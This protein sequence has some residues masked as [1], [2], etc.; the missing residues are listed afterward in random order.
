MND[1]F[2]K[3][4][5]NIEQL[6]DGFTLYNGVQ[7]PVLGFGTWLMPNDDLGIASVRKALEAGYRHI[8]TAAV[9]KNEESVRE[10]I[11]QS[12][13]PREEIFLTTKLAN[14]EHGYETSLK[15]FQASLERLGTDY[16]D[17][18]LIHWP[19][20]A[21]FR[22]CWEEANAETWRAFEE[23]YEA[24][25]IRAIGVSNFREHHLEALAK[26]WK[27]KPMVN[28]IHLCPGNLPA[29]QVAY[30]LDREILIESYSPL[31]RGQILEIETLRELAETKA[32]TIPQI[33]LRWHLQKGFVAL[34]KSVTPVY[35]KE[36][37]QIFDFVLSV[38]EM[39]V[40]DS[41][42]E[43]SCGSPT[44]PDTTDF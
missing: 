10:G 4:A 43:G 39:A 33:V 14:P 22:N 6:S 31:G 26:S 40:I 3:E 12:G 35:I 23:L 25:K 32:K 28:Q 36:N 42:L 29:S 16:V 21:K 34:P 1:Q 30:C 11:R 15:A 5:R 2:V 17:L 37:A 41:V 19:N 7:I 24:G 18:Y 44:D 38:D 9:Y 13:V 27:I 20:P 8:D